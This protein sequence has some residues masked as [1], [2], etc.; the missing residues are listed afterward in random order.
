M[1]YVVLI[2]VV[3]A[4]SNYIN[5]IVNSWLEKVGIIHL[6]QLPEP[7]GAATVV[8]GFILACVIA[9]VF[10]E[11]FYRGVILSLLKGYGNGAA[12]VVSALMFA[13]AHG[14]VT[15]VTSTFACGIILGYVTVRSGSLLPAMIIHFGNNFISWAIQ[16]CGGNETLNIAT[17]LFM[18]IAGSASVIWAL[19]KLVR[20]RKRVAAVLTQVWG[21]VKNPLWIPIVADFVLKNFLYHG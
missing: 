1:K 21:Y 7:D 4:A 5:I 18:I 17:V 15:L 8:A 2:P 9:P 13:F 10:E 16:Y 19:I 6:Q 11:L 14:S 20:Q 12:V 3:W